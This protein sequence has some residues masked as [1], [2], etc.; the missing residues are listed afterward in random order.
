MPGFSFWIT[1]RLGIE[2]QRRYVLDVL[3]Y[4]KFNNL[5]S[6][7][8]SCNDHETNFHI[9]QVDNMPFYS[10]CWANWSDSRWGIAYLQSSRK[11]Y[12]CTYK[13]GS[14]LASFACLCLFLT[15]SAN[16]ILLTDLTYWGDVHN[17]YNHCETLEVRS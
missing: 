1:E 16:G 13:I 5:N 11:K 8:F 6:F 2:Y 14:E 9:I 17:R 3:F 7:R 4:V 10:H 12:T 15:Y